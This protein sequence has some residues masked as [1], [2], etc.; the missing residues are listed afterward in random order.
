MSRLLIMV[1]GMG[2]F[3]A[4]WSQELIDQLDTL[5]MQYPGLAGQPKPFSSA[6]KIA[7]VLYD[8]VLATYVDRIKRD[9]DELNKFANDAGLA[10]TGTTR[11]LALGTLPQTTTDFF[12]TTLID[13]IF[14]RG[15]PLVRD[16]VRNK[17]EFQVA[18]IITQYLADLPGGEQP[19]VSVLSHSLGTAVIHDV[20]Q[21]LATQPIDGNSSLTSERFSLDSLFALADVSHLGPPGLIDIDSYASAVRPALGAPAPPGGFK[22]YLQRCYNFR[23]DFDPF[24]LWPRQRF[25]PPWT[26]PG[27]PA[28][29][30]IRHVHQ[31]NVHGF[32]HYLKNPVV[33]IPLFRR[34]LGP[35]VISPADEA[36]AIAKF[37]AI[38]PPAC[39]AMVARLE[40]DL[41]SLTEPSP[42][43]VEFFDDL[44][45]TARDMLDAIRNAKVACPTM[46]SG[47]PGI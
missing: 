35:G 15:I 37:P 44:F 13:P 5:A 22:P 26:T 9:A 46:L 31:I 30:Q 20:L 41:S 4:Q 11:L 1:H 3:Q 8:P 29:P 19:S 42:N 6:V 2:S 38:D 16:D 25:S 14:Y 33:H 12:W 45:L 17:V 23:H 47:I 32:Y 27:Y 10:L 18:K 28:P 43:P 7:E 24:C 39:A 40:Q 21:L 36:A 34:L